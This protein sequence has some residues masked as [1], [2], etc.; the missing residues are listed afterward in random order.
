MNDFSFCLSENVIISKYSIIENY[1][2]YYFINEEIIKYFKVQN[3]NGFKKAFVFIN[4][5][6]LFVFYLGQNFLLKVENYK[7]K[8]FNLKKL[9][10][11]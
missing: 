8:T 2:Q 5:K 10:Q 1:I 11:Q 7:N 4:Q 3:I 9:T 6:R